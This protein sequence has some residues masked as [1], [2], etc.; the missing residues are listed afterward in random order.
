MRQSSQIGGNKMSETKADTTSMGL[1]VISFLMLVFALVGIFAFTEYDNALGLV[2][3][4]FMAAFAAGIVFAFV[5][6]AM[7]KANN[8]FVMIIFATLTVFAIVYSGTFWGTSLALVAGAQWVFL[9]LA[10][11]VIVYAL[12]AFLNKAGFMLTLLLLVTGLA[13]LFLFLACNVTGGA[14]AADAQTFMLLVGLFS[15]IGFIL[16]LWMALADNTDIGLPVM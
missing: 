1:F 6:F 15:L 2:G 8:K 14:L 4:S 12:I 7:W 16:A 5:T 9:V 13:V 10:I 3:G 11:I